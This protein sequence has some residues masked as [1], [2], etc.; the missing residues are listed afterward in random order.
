MAYPPGSTWSPPDDETTATPATT[1]YDPSP[2]LVLQPWRLWPQLIVALLGGILPAAVIAHLNGQR[3]GLSPT[4]LRLIVA[5]GVIGLLAMLALS[6]GRAV[7]VPLLMPGEKFRAV[8][9]VGALIGLSAW[10][11]FAF[12]QLPASR[13]HYDRGGDYGKLWAPGVIAVLA[14]GIPQRLMIWGAVML[15]TLS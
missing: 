14:F 7:S 5:V 6:Y 1:G 10:P 13:G 4:R 3:L 11:L 15:L 9:A 12:L 8:Q 2:F